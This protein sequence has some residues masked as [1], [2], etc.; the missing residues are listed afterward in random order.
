MPLLT[1]KG[2]GTQACSLSL[3]CLPAICQRL[4]A[5][6]PLI[7]GAYRCALVESLKVKGGEYDPQLLIL[8][9]FHTLAVKLL[10]FLFSVIPVPMD[11]GSQVM[12][13]IF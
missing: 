6:F 12:D 11:C 3:R 2:L 4:V 9:F 1:G 5:R 7:G 8:P 13:R 10:I